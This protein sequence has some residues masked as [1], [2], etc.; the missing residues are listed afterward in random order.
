MILTKMALPRRTFLRGLGATLGLPL[1]EAMVPA[2]TA[3]A[4]TAAKP[5]HRVA[6]FYVPNG[7][8]LVNWHPK[9]EGASFDITPIL[10]P[11]TP[12]RDRMVVVSGLANSQADAL[13]VGSGSHARAAGVWLNGVRPKRTEGADIRA[14]TTIDQ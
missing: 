2:F 3:I 7:I 14:G 12:F 11:L 8:Q 9:A 5:I 13:D 10:S 1:L 6:F 4:Q